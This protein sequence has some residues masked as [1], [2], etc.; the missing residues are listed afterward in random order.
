MPIQQ[1]LSSHTPPGNSAPPDCGR[2]PGTG[3]YEVGILQFL[4]DKWKYHDA[5]SYA[6]ERLIVAVLTGHVILAGACVKIAADNNVAAAVFMMFQGIATV[7]LIY[8][9][10]AQIRRHRTVRNSFNK[11]IWRELVSLDLAKQAPDFAPPDN[12]E[13]DFNSVWSFFERST[14][15]EGWPAP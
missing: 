3:S 9:Q 7:G 13:V 12:W 10:Q 5:Y 6:T 8:H 11:E 4:F 15:A 14:N 1:Q 2:G